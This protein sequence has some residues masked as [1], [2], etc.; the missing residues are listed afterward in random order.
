MMQELFLFIYLLIML[1]SPL[2]ENIHREILPLSSFRQVEVQFSLKH[3]F[4]IHSPES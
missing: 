1:I 4:M 3:Q 2:P